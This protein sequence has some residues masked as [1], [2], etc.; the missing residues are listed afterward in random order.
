MKAT[1]TNPSAS[2]KWSRLTKTNHQPVR[3]FHRGLNV[4][5]EYNPGPVLAYGADA[6]ITAVGRL[7]LCP[8]LTAAAALKTSNKAERPQLVGVPRAFIIGATW[9]VAKGIGGGIYAAG[10][11]AGLLYLGTFCVFAYPVVNAGKIIRVVD[12]ELGT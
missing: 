3:I 10:S 9:G 11:A 5:D 1:Q 7:L 12:R 4:D 8:A 6:A 2:H